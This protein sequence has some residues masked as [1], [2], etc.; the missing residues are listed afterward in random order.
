M[1]SPARRSLRIAHVVPVAT[2]VPP[3]KSGSVQSVASLLTEGLVAAGHDVTLFA[4]GDSI[5][6]AR[7]H[8][9]YP[10]G[11]LHDDQMWPWEL[12]DMLNVA[13]AVERAR[14]FDIIHVEA[15]YYPISL[16]FSRLSP[17]PV[18]QTVHHAPSAAELSLWRRYPEAPFV[19]ISQEQA[20]LLQG[21]NVVS[22]VL[23]AI[24]LSR[25]AYRDRPDD[26]L[27]FLGRFTEGKGVL[28]AI[29]V[30][31]RRSMKLLLAAAET[32]YYRGQVAPYVDGQQI[33]YVGEVDSEAKVRLC[34]GAR[35]LLY[36]VQAGEP[37][38]LVLTEAMACGTPVAALDRGA[39][40]EIVD[41]GVTGIVFEGVDEM[42]SGLNR[43][44]ALDRATVRRRATERF[45][46]AVMVDGYVDAY[47][48]IIDA[49]TGSA[50]R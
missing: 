13:A 12:Y 26:Y 23:H 11:Y 1:M 27:L 10:H 48:A 8:A 39:V 40:R 46:A 41:E 7:L 19:A 5:T 14:D 50:P 9:T 37:F 30:A 42:V 36:P 24:D 38:G 31:K 4:T 29:D 45:S 35:A 33:I 34:G 44:L 20:R 15:G 2:S 28:Q 6:R 22:V 32:D 47:H 16:A 18:V 21:L 17:V 43:V 3:K 25:F 49:W